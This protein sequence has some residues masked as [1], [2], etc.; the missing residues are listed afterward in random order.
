MRL[1]QTTYSDASPAALR[2]RMPSCAARFCALLD[3]SIMFAPPI[4]A[5]LEASPIIGAVFAANE[6]PV[7]DDGLAA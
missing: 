6:E 7:S 2:L 3:A 5:Y 1:N 4:A